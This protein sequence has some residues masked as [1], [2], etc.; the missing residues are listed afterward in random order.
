MHLSFMYKN[1]IS[2]EIFHHNKI[3]SLQIQVIHLGFSFDKEIKEQI[4]A[5]YWFQLTKE[6]VQLKDFSFSKSSTSHQ[7]R[8]K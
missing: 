5:S 2:L 1:S 4:Q 7:L 6:I 3:N 8:V